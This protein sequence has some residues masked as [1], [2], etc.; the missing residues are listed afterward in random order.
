M[1]KVSSG[2]S[3]AGAPDDRRAVGSG[4]R[5]PSP[6]RRRSPAGRRGVRSLRL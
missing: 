6:A 3:T 4:G 1:S 2:T 5:V